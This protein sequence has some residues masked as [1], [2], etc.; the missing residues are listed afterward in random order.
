[1][2]AASRGGSIC[3]YLHTLVYL[4]CHLM[5]NDRH[6]ELQ[7]YFLPLILYCEKNP[8]PVMFSIQSKCLHSNDP[9]NFFLRK[10]KSFE[11]PHFM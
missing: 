11:A 6:F 1:M 7:F 3:V 8:F 4:L 9:P 2:A 10:M 5:S